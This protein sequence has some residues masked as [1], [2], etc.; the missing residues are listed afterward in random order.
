MHTKREIFLGFLWRET[1][2]ISTSY[3]MSRYR[4]YS[5]LFA[6]S[7]SLCYRR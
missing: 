2:Y 3:L 5:H 1:R 7:L 6:L 4:V